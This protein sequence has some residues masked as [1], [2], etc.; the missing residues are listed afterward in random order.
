MMTGGLFVVFVFFPALRI[1]PS[2]AI[3][4]AEIDLRLSSCLDRSLPASAHGDRNASGFGNR[5]RK[6][7]AARFSSDLPSA[8]RP[9]TARDR[10]L[11]RVRVRQPP[12]LA[13]GFGC[14][15]YR[16]YSSRLGGGL[17]CA[18]SPSADLA[19]ARHPFESLERQSGKC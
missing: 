3:S 15:A 8:G 18:R 2:R 11:C 19:R 16:L 13:L 1:W 12:G 6:A 17:W 10:Q 4:T 5:A 9:L 7:L 14:G